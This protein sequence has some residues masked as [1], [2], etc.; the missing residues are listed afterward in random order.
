MHYEFFHHAG[1]QKR[2]GTRDINA[3]KLTNALRQFF[4]LRYYN[5]GNCRR[6][7]FSLGF[8]KNRG[9]ATKEPRNRIGWNLRAL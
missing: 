1:G 9:R 6:V 7:N 5:V 4:Q 8:N 3:F 2:A